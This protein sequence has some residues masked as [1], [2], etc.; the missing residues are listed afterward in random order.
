M[1]ELKPAGILAARMPFMALCCELS[2]GEGINKSRWLLRFICSTIGRKNHWADKIVQISDQSVEKLA[3]L[4][5]QTVRLVPAKRKSA[6][7]FCFC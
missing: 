1:R 7:A 4:M 5:E 2:V 3:R 6:Y